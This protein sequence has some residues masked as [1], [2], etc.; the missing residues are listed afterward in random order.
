MPAI[1]WSINLGNLL[2]IAGFL[3][4]GVMFVIKV[5]E[6]VNAARSE[7]QSLA[8]MHLQKFEALE[9]RHD[10]RE[11]KH[12]ERFGHLEKKVDVIAEATVAI[13]RQDERMNGFEH[14]LASIEDEVRTR[15]ERV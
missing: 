9:K 1:D 10:E 7:Q 15:R 8:A 11:K 14:R 6:D 2:T 13:A 4:G 12:D 5:R 3:F